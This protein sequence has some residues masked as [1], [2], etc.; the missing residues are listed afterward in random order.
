ME[1]ITIRLKTNKKETLNK[2]TKEVNHKTWYPVANDT[3]GH[4]DFLSSS[5]KV[6][7]KMLI[8]YYYIRG[9]FS[10]FNSDEIRLNVLKTA[11]V[12]EV[13]RADVIRTISTLN[14]KR[15]EIVETKEQFNFGAALGPQQGPDGAATGSRRGRIEGA[16]E[17]KN[18]E[19]EIREEKK[20]TSST[21]VQAPECGAIKE[22]RDDPDC[23]FLLEEIN[24]DTQVRWCRLYQHDFEYLRRE[25]IKARGWL[26]NNPKRK[27]S[28]S[29]G[30]SQFLGNWLSRGWEQHRKTIAT[31]G[32]PQA[33]KFSERMALKGLA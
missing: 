11:K 17:E 33:L 30:T 16:R 18:R 9:V 28:T 5:A 20:T 4:H 12:T 25:L 15:W 14:L 2:K 31:N 21:S 7:H 13:S 23:E 3:V 6:D 29:K 22:L 8:V 27:P 26:E 24:H 10:E 1:E 32:P 19:E